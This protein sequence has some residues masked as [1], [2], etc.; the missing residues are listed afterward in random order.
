MA[1]GQLT[2]SKD[3]L[4]VAPLLGGIAAYDESVTTGCIGFLSYLGGM[5]DHAIAV[6]YIPRSVNRT[7]VVMRWLVRA[8]AVEG[9]DY[10][11]AKLCWLW[12][13]TTKQDKSI[14]ELNAAG[15]ASRG[16]TPGPYSHLEGMTADFVDRYLALMS[17][18]P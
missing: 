13:E 17:D 9:R 15:V 5:C 14:I 3:G 18:P 4:G 1:P 8:D 7:D 16:Y 10:D 12:D 2:A 11:V 6:T